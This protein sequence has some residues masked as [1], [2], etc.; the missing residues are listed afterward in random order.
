MTRT[1]DATNQLTSQR[2]S[3]AWAYDQAD[4]YDALGT[5]PLED[6]SGA[7][8]T[9]MYDLANQLVTSQ[10]AAGATT[11]TH[12]LA[13][14]LHI[15]EQP[16]G[17]RTTTTW[18]D[19]NR[20]TGVLLPD[21]SAVTNTYRF[22]GLRYSKQGPQATTRFL[23]DVNN[24]LAETD[25]DDEIQAIY[26]NEP[27]QYG[28][29]ISQ[30][31]KGPTLWLPSYYHYDA[32]GS[33]RVLTNDA[34][35]V[36]DTYVYDAWGNAI[37]S[38]GSAHNPFRWVGRLGYY[39]EEE[40]GT[41]YIRA[42]VYE[43]VTGRW[44]SRDPLFSLV[45]K[46]RFAGNRRDIEPES[47]R[48]PNRS[49]VPHEHSWLQRDSAKTQET[50]DLYEYCGT[51]PIANIDPSGRVG[52]TPIIGHASCYC[53][54]LTCPDV[55]GAAILMGPHSRLMRQLKDAFPDVAG[56]YE[57]PGPFG[58]IGVVDD[59]PANALMHCTA[60]CRLTKLIGPRC[61][62]LASACRERAGGPPEMLDMHNDREGIK[63]A[64]GWDCATS[65]KAKLD[66]GVLM[67]R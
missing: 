60:A 59:S 14:N 62:H 64:L 37:A 53:L 30:Y 23:W 58:G 21:G 11:Y 12:D 35:V 31:R 43:P 8:T 57:G 19:Q 54:L 36:T 56:F 9:S 33:T 50:V 38:T 13:G 63:S 17:Q 7:L 1:Y 46:T 10:H 29:L 42:R 32:L 4:T 65:C 2:R 15:V 16:T 44:M 28:N 66:N 24:Y 39:W 47:D 45:A 27:Q 51:S 61:A 41:F 55:I 5:R 67:T 20:Q 52:I 6:A 26:T 18:D 3:S 49:F 48:V 34:G 25:A 40:L 22:D